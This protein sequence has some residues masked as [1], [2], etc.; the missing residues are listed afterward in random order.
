MSFWFNVDDKG[1]Y[2]E[3]DHA[4]IL[5]N[6]PQPPFYYVGTEN[7]HKYMMA[8]CEGKAL[9]WNDQDK[10]L[11]IVE[12]PGPTPEQLDSHHR[13]IRATLLTEYDGA[14][15]QLNRFAEEDETNSDALASYKKQ[16]LKWH[17]WANDLCAMPDNESW[18]WDLDTI[19]WPPRP[20]S[21]TR[22]S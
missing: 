7:H 13:E 19:P 15:S 6:D 9:E 20:V 16:R 21:P 1:F 3:E 17:A 4:E 11:E 14:V 2:H 18:P 8:L 22:F 10:V 12:L 5:G